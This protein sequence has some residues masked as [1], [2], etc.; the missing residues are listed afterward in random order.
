MARNK[1]QGRKQNLFFLILTIIFKLLY[2]KA[3][4]L[5]LRIK[6]GL[7]ILR[8]R[9]DV[10]GFIIHR[11]INNSLG[12]EQVKEDSILEN[13]NKKCLFLSLKLTH[14]LPSVRREGGVKGQLQ[15]TGK[16]NRKEIQWLDL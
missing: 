13:E 5:Q 6:K 2:L 3:Y 15:A 9:S 7:L 12:T 10:H 4:L 16:L 11:L 1:Q 14:F 8:F